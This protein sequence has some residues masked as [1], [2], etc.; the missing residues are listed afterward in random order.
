MSRVL[1]TGTLP[2]CAFNRTETKLSFTA[3]CSVVRISI[4]LRNGFENL[5]YFPRDKVA[6]PCEGAVGFIYDRRAS[7]EHQTTR[8]HMTSSPRTARRADRRWWRGNGGA[9]GRWGLP[10][11]PVHRCAGFSEWRCWATRWLGVGNPLGENVRSGVS[12]CQTGK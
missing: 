6:R 10:W 7:R 11:N 3:N 8:R 12:G 5:R 2:D 4:G 9:R 1:K